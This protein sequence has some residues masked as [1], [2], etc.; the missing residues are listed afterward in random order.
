MGSLSSYGR[1]K[2][3][4]ESWMF[5]TTQ[6]VQRLAGVSLRML[7][8]WEQTDV[9]SAT[10]IDERT[11]VPY[12]RIYTFRDLVSLRTLAVLRRKYRVRLD[13]LRK[14]GQFLRQRYDAPWA[15]LTFGV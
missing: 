4:N 2:A 14:A 12:R 13:E 8:Y 3:M 6:Q 1:S 9:F 11:R 15:E 7:R 10:Y 5:F